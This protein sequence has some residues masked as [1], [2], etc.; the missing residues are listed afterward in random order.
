MCGYIPRR[1]NS[2]DETRSQETRSGFREQ[3]AEPENELGS[4]VE[5]FVLF[6]FGELWGASEGFGAVE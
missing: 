2:E 3:L 6:L 1:K 5:E 4:H